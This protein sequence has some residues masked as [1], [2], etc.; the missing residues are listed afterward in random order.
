MQE[1]MA[2]AWGGLDSSRETPIIPF[3]CANRFLERPKV[4]TSY[5]GLY[6]GVRMMEVR[7]EG[8]REHLDYWTQIP[9]RS[10]K[11]NIRSWLK[12]W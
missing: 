2:M 1:Q 8:E 9:R 3:E 4:T 6:V 12:I 11:G 10:C 5:P 7:W